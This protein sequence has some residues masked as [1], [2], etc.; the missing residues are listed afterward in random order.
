MK[1]GRDQEA[2]LV[3]SKINHHSKKEMFVETCLE[4]EELREVTRADSGNNYSLLLK[5]LFRYKYRW[6]SMKMYAACV[7]VV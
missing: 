3:L 6:L 7:N 5:E 1:K 4:L 2:L